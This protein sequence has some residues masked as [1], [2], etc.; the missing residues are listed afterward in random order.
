MGTLRHAI[1]HDICTTLSQIQVPV[2]LMQGERDPIIPASWMIT[3]LGLLP[4][5]RL[6]VIPGAA[7][8]INFNA[9]EAVTC[10]VLKFVADNSIALHPPAGLSFADQGP[11]AA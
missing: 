8:A 7:H 9:P 5:A 3:A 1:Q 2:L 10:E 11:G 6:V 4:S